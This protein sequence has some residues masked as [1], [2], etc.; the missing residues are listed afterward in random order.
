VANGLAWPSD[1]R[2]Y[3]ERKQDTQ[4]LLELVTVGPQGQLGV[5]HL[6]HQ[7]CPRII[8]ARVSGH[9]R[10]NARC[11]AVGRVYQDSVQVVD[12]TACN[13]AGRLPKHGRDRWLA[14]AQVAGGRGKRMSQRVRRHARHAGS[15][16]NASEAMGKTAAASRQQD[17]WAG[18]DARQGRE[19]LEC[20]LADRPC[21]AAFLCIVRRKHVVCPASLETADAM[22]AIRHL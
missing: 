3:I 6:G 18:G 12:V 13:A 20:G 10:G 7:L 15:L 21:R 2:V 17:V 11:D 22:T 5:R 16:R 9:R 19:N 1:S 8:L 4:P 14:V